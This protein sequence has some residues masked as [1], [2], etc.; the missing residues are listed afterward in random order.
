MPRTTGL[1]HRP[2]HPKPSI[3]SRPAA[4]RPAT[5][6]TWSEVPDVDGSETLEEAGDARD[7]M[8]SYEASRSRKPSTR[9]LS[10]AAT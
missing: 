4:T 9:A 10:K 7:P 8:T 6:P 5:T 1:F 2:S 3:C